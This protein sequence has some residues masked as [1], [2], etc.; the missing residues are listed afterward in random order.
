MNDV[1]QGQRGSFPACSICRAIRDASRVLRPGAVF[2]FASVAGD[3][4]MAEP[5][6]VAVGMRVTFAVAAGIILLE[7]VITAASRRL[8]KRPSLGESAEQRTRD[9]EQPAIFVIVVMREH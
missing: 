8:I 6:A 9:V 7:P 5:Q 4:T 3:I 1:A 2:A